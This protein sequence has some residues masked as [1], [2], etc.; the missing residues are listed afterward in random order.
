MRHHVRCQDHNGVIGYYPQICQEV[1]VNTIKRGMEQRESFNTN[2]IVKKNTQV[3]INSVPSL[4][5]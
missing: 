5:L 1:N 4:P 3:T 2:D